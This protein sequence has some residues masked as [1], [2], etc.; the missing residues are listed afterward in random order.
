MTYLQPTMISGFALGEFLAFWLLL[1]LTAMSDRRLAKLRAKPKDEWLLDIMG[2][3]FQGIIIPGLESTVVYQLYHYFWPN[4][5][6]SLTVHPLI[7][8]ALSFV[9]IDYLYYWNHRLLHSQWFWPLHQVHHTMSQREVLGTSRNTLWTSFF[10]L[11]LWVHPGFIYLL[12]DARGYIAGVSLTVILDLWRHSEIDP[13]PNSW[14]H[15]CL[16]FWLI[17]PQDHGWHHGEIPRGNYG[18]NLKVWDRIHGTDYFCPNP[19]AS[20][21]IKTDLTLR[22]KLFWPFKSSSQAKTN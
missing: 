22:Q 11:Y 8:F 1:G 12:T 6:Q 7:G 15:R 18:A 19:P 17:L 21:G 9:G 5:Q 3:L 14:L 20:L 2:L 10:I 13:P 4:L 16:N